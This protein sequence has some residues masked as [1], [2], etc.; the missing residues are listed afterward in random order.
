MENS[1]IISEEDLSSFIEQIE[2]DEKRREQ[3]SENTKRIFDEAKSTGLDPKVMK[4]VIKHRK[5][6][7]DEIKKQETLLALY[8]KSLGMI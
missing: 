7:S 6:T 5:M 2:F 8:K 3:I 4:Q 1:L